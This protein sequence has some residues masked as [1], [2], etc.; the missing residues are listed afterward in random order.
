MPSDEAHNT[1]F[2]ASVVHPVD[3]MARPLCGSDLFA[4]ERFGDRLS[5]FDFER[6]SRL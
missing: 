5:Q 2:V 4:P 1:A 6:D 3:D